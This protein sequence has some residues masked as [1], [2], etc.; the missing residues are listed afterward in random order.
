MIGR[1][2]F[3]TP[4]QSLEEVLGPGGEGV[5]PAMVDSL[6]PTLLV[7]VMIAVVL[8][9]IMSTVDSL[10][11]VASSAFVR[12]YYQK[13]LHPELPD[14]ALVSMS[15]KTTAVLA[16]AALGVALTVA[17]LSPDRTIF[18]FVIFGWSGIAATFCPTMVLSLFWKGMTARGALVAMITGFVS[19]PFFKFV[20]P[21]LP[22]V[23]PAFG[24]LEEMTPAFLLGGIAGVVVSLA[25]NKGRARLKD[26]VL[27]R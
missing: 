26:L 8:S 15:R 11:I 5:L 6:L 17:A 10:L 3:L 4:G 20:A 1:H 13:T 16:L 24:T 25:D 19:V 7:G 9:A 22:G 27:S 18:W 14:A 12:D 21:L 23:G 2:L